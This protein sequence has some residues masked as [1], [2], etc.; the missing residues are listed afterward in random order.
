MENKICYYLIVSFYPYSLIMVA[1]LLAKKDTAAAVSRILGH[2][3]AESNVAVVI[4]AKRFKRD[5]RKPARTINKNSIIIN[6]KC[7]QKTI[8]L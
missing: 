8:L 7:F 6:N 3:N 2:F 4:N 5:L 1:K